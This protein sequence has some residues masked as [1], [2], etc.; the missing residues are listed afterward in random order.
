MGLGD[1]YDAE[2]RT[3]LDWSPDASLNALVR[4]SWAR[5]E[6]TWFVQCHLLCPQTVGY[7]QANTATFFSG[8]TALCHG[9]SKG[10]AVVG[11][12][13]RAKTLREAADA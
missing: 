13:S 3:A 7:N 10:L 6:P 5:R 2:V 1:A 9:M 4:R 8:A 12:E 11:G